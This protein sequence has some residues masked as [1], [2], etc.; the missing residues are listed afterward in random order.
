MEKEQ[1]KIRVGTSGYSFDDW[2]G[3][4]YPADIQKG[5]MLD[6]YVRFFSTV[7]INSTYYR[8]PHPAV[9]ANI[10]KK[11]PEGFDFMVK[12]PQ[13][14]THRRADLQKDVEK[15]RTALQPFEESGKLAGL[16]AQFP[17]S[18]KYGQDSLDFVSVC[19]DAVAP[20]PLFVEFRHNSWVNRDMYDR[21]KK[22]KIGYVC[23]DEPQL[24]G[25]LKPDLFATTETA[26]IRLHGRNKAQW[27]DGGPLRYDY[28]YSEEELS[29]WKQKLVKIRNKVKNIYI[30]FNNCHLGQA[31]GNA[32][33][34]MG[35]LGL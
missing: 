26:Y 31:S 6:Y 33:D 16:L 32:R 14:F 27:W 5:K 10:V 4:F 8:I 9:M 3:K 20:N 23:V 29:E 7:E 35:M 17:Y 34:F 28:S 30:Y 19:R 21:L 1:A 11:A 13:T 2:K 24:S 15:F 22:E 25:L 12:V 18:F